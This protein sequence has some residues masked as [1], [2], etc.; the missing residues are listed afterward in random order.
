MDIKLSA[1]YLAGI[2]SNK[3][4]IEKSYLPRML[5]LDDER[6]DIIATA[7]IKLIDDG[8]S[9]SSPV[10]LDA[11]KTAFLSIAESDDWENEREWFESFVY[12]AE[13]MDDITPLEIE[14][15]Y[16]ILQRQKLSDQTRRI[17]ASVVEKIDFEEEDID[18][19]LEK[20]RLIK[21]VY[22]S[23]S[24]KLDEQTASAVS[25]A[26]NNAAG[27]VPYGFKPIDENI[28]GVCRKEIT[29]VAGRPGHGKTSI[30]CQFVLN[31]IQ[32]GLKVLFISKEMP[33]S[34]LMH[35]FFSNIGNIPSDDIKRGAVEDPDYLQSI[36]GAFVD[37]FSKNLFMYDNVYSSPEIERL[38]LKHKPD[39]IIDD[40]IQL[41]DFGNSDIRLGILKVLKHYKSLAKENDCA[42]VVLSQLS[43]SIEG[44]DDPIPRMSDLAESGA[45][46]QLAADVC[47][48]FYEYKVTYEET[49][50]NRVDFI[51]AKARYGESTMVPLGFDGSKM[52]YYPIPKFNQ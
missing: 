15:L 22:P 27:L 6:H 8:S 44:R 46:E 39:I 52:R 49:L 42:F 40:F 16:N 31:W 38:I 33:V 18:E 37:K 48:I 34:R 43:R 19:A 51:V 3:G 21:A 24:A 2:I 10:I 14:E 35:K 47:F 45:L 32:A 1:R 28:G 5:K 11:I 20:L 41:S 50:K 13:G 12:T 25:D 17:L 7:I 36:A 29:I 26:L 4:K 23:K 30:V 9:L